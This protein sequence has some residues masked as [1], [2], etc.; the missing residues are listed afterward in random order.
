MAGFGETCSHVGALLFAVE[1]GVRIN[2]AKTC[3]SLP[4]KWLMP[5]PVTSVPYQELRNMDFTSS[6][7]KKKKLDTKINE[8]SEFGQDK[9]A[10]DK[11]T[12]VSSSTSDTS[13]T[14]HVPSPSQIKT[15]FDQ[16]HKCESHAAILSL[17]TPYN[18]NFL[19]KT[20]LSSL[21]EPLTQLYSA[22]LN[23]VGYQTLLAK[24]ID[25]FQ[26]MDISSEQA[27]LIEEV[28]KSQS[29]SPLWFQMRAGRITASKFYKACHTDPASPS[30]SLIKEVCYG[31][32]FTSKAT[33]WGCTHENEAVSQYKQVSITH[34]EL[35]ICSVLISKRYFQVSYIPLDSAQVSNFKL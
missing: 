8:L 31:S 6:K 15:F 14:K 27:K 12:V 9:L 5:T 35:E 32:S 26:K 13:S 2:K 4:C 3:T 25:I 34:A 33:T 21:P 20:D 30:V 22:E 28:T 7:T 24:S 10:L 1:A 23:S 17:T 11:S 18:K 19:P 29:K 16:L